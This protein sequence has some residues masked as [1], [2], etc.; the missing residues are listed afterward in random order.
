[1]RI[2][3]AAFSGRRRMRR[4]TVAARAQQ[5]VDP[6][7]KV[8]FAFTVDNS[9]PPRDTYQ[10]SRLNGHPEMLLV[11]GDRK[12]V[13]IRADDVARQ[14]QDT[15]PVLVFHRYG[16]EYVLREVRLE[17]TARLDFLETKA[18]RQAAE[19]RADRASAAMQTVIVA[20]EQR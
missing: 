8:P 15:E 16:D 17:G 1:M 19:R 10:L 13:M 6:V 7:A 12:S 18:E 9:Q 11:R 4:Q 20:A 14:P 2:A 5:T 3:V